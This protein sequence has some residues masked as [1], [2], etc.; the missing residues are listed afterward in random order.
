MAPTV[1]PAKQAELLRLPVIVVD[2][3]ATSRT[4]LREMTAGWG[5]DV[6]AVDS[7]P[8]ATS[9][10]QPAVISRRIVLLV[11]LSSTTITGKRSSSACFAGTTV[12]AIPSATPSRTV[13]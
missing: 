13:K 7:G 5:M 12:G 10:P 8:A 6:A 3:N 9:I 1:V 4:I 2:D 11:A